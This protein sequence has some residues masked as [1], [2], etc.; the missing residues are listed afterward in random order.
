MRMGLLGLRQGVWVDRGLSLSVVWRITKHLKPVKG[1]LHSW[2]IEIHRMDEMALFASK[3]LSV[4]RKQGVLH[5]QSRS[6]KAFCWFVVAEG[7]F[8]SHDGGISS[9]FR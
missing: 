8:A 5:R 3:M 9:S 7:C 6:K 4:D 1:F 2:T